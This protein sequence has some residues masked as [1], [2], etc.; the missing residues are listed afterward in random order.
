[1]RFSVLGPIELCAADELISLGPLKQRT[2]LAALLVDAGRPVMPETLIG[3]VWD[4]T[5]PAEVRNVMYTY[6]TR[7][8]RILE[9]AERVSGH[10]VELRRQSGGYL[11]NVDP[12]RVDLHSF[13]ST[14]GEARAA[15]GDIEMRAAR[16]RAA[17][18]LW[19]GTP[20]ADISGA[21]AERVR[22]WL[23]RQ[24]LDALVEW[25]DLELR[26]GRPA[27]VIDALGHALAEQPF[28]E[29]LIGQLLRAL[30]LAGRTAEAL[31]FYAAAR[32]R[33]I[34]GIGAEPGPA[35]RRLHE[36]IL[37]EEAHVVSWVSQTR[38]FAISGS[39]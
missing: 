22:E 39:H 26:L 5:P 1:M 13:R 10:R 6:V 14:I 8:R 35:V 36:A 12:G 11:L 7:L 3:R 21:W 4:E 19:Q 24:R 30:S 38:N 17:L 28:A 16:L 27:I 32:Q 34:D 31:E 25:S 2:V 15:V 37:R 29:A 18:G 23:Q 33:I 9:Y 20:L